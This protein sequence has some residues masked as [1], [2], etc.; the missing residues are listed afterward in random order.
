MSQ[1]G[2][3]SLCNGRTWDD[4][5]DSGIEDGECNEKDENRCDAGDD[6]EY[7]IMMIVMVMVMK[8]IIMLNFMWL[9]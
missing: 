3:D 6:G 5:Q 4:F 8:M 2:L 9:K 7:D 1:L